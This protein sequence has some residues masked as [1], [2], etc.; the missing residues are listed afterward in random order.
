MTAWKLAL[1]TS[2]YALR[3]FLRILL[4]AFKM[5]GSNNPHLTLY[6]RRLG[7]LRFPNLMHKLLIKSKMSKTT[8]WSWRSSTGDLRNRNIVHRKP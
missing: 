1:Y 5:L 4:A 6:R 7:I 8:A 3:T 2:S